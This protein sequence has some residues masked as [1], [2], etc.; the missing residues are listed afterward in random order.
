MESALIAISWSSAIDTG[1]R[2]AQPAPTIAAYIVSGTAAQPPV[3]GP[4]HKLAFYNIGWKS[5]SKK[6]NTAWLAREVSD[7]VT[8]KN[9]DAISISEVFNQ[10]ENLKDRRQVIM[11]EL[12]KHLNQGST[13]HPAWEGKQTLTASSFGIRTDCVW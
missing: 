12:L 13:E 2:A 7:I 10:R 11:S 1:C 4:T 3:Q 8:T 6:H 9:V 5:D